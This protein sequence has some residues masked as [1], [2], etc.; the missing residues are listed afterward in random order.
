MC[1]KRGCLYMGGCCSGQRKV[2]FVHSI[3]REKKYEH[4]VRTSKT[5]QNIRK[6]ALNW[7]WT[8]VKDAS[9]QKG[10]TSPT[11]TLSIK[12]SL[13]LVIQS[14][15]KNRAGLVGRFKQ[16]QFCFYERIPCSLLVWK[17]SNQLLQCAAPFPTNNNLFKLLSRS[18]E[19]GS[20][21]AA[22]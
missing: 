15:W 21:V 10:S 11:F 13:L 7:I 17:L 1:A 6:V 4:S 3:N 18:A 19:T 2:P 16:N 14:V 12:L 22:V 20:A 5:V 9:G 8:S